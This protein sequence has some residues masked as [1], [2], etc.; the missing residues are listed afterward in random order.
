MRTHCATLTVLGGA[1]V[2]RRAPIRRLLVAIALIAAA[3]LEATTVN[4]EITGLG[5]N[6]YHFEY[7]VSGIQFQTNQELDIQFDPALFGALSNP[8]SGPG[9]DV[10]IF[11]PNNPPGSSGDY[12][13]LALVNNPSSLE[14]GVDV[15]FLGS[16]PP[17][18]Q[19][20][21]INQFDAMG[22]FVSTLQS[23]TTQPLVQS[24][25]PEPGS[26]T[27]A[28]AGLLLYGAWRGMRRRPGYL[29]L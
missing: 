28:G 15:I 18:S 2:R 4:V 17:G 12:S 3:K 19:P 5:G 14:F 27:M 1:P 8:T 13:A 9:F 11:Q 7:F 10:M 25:A 23:G 16:G 26:W 29:R 22:R 6:A 24:A 21:E 20:F